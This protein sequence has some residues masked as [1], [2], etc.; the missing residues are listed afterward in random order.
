M[1]H[2]RKTLAEFSKI[3]LRARDTCTLSE[4]VDED[5]GEGGFAARVV[6]GMRRANLVLRESD[7]A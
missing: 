4:M 3:Y 1:D 7:R 5:N 6:L 2:E